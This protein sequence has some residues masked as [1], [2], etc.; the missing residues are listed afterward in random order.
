MSLHWRRWGRALAD[1]AWP[2]HCLGCERPLRAAVA[3]CPACCRGLRRA[4]GPQCRLCSA[5]LAQEGACRN[6]V[7]W[8]PVFERALVLGDFSSSMQ[9]AV[10]RLKFGGQ[11]AV[12]RQLGRLLGRSFANELAEV[13]A[14]VPVPLHAAR[15]RERGYN[16]S[17][18][19]ALGITEVIDLPVQPRAL[20]RCRATPAQ[21]RLDAAGRRANLQGAFVL[22]RPLAGA[23]LRV[24]L[25]DDV[26]SSGATL[27]AAAAVLRGAGHR[28]WAVA[29]GCPFKT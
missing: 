18:L 5:P 4:R 12:G 24:G 8:Q 28:V 7:D 10:H 21:A 26:L 9:R 14:L 2:P 25:V 17:L 27:G 6:C 23:G 3:F 11:A 20:I 29:A 15:Q 13:D 1:F 22:G 16:Q 19:I